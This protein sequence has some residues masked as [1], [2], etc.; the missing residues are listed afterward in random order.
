MKALERVKIQQEKKRLELNGETAAMTA[1]EK[2]TFKGKF[3]RLMIFAND[4]AFPLLMT[5]IAYYLFVFLGFVGLYLSEVKE[6]KSIFSVSLS[7]IYL[8]FMISYFW[9]FVKRHKR[10]Q[11]ATKIKENKNAV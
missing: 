11:Q 10:E 6:V 7:Q 1:K 8:I 5:T 3:I 2:E 9:V 4:M